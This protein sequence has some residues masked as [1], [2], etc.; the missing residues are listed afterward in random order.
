MSIAAH[1]DDPFEIRS[2]PLTRPFIWIGKGWDDLLHHRGASLAY[3]WL[4]S[5]LA[6]LI[7]AFERHPFFIAFT[8]TVF[9]LVGPVMTAGLAE[10][11]RRQE[12][13]ETAN[14]A[15]SLKAL[16]HHRRNLM[17][18]SNRL[19]ALGPGGNDHKYLDLSF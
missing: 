9:L 12:H 19:L 11:S 16:R 6:V 14:F 10:L 4:V 8:I 17:G 13:G 3:G 5:T 2:V 15:T 1:P 18:F 7:L